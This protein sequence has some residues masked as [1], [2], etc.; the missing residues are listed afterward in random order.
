MVVDTNMT[1]SQSSKEK[2]DKEEEGLMSYAIV[3]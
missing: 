1:C 3:E 2:G